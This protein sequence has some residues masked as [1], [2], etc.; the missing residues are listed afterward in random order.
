MR[1]QSDVVYAKPT[2]EPPHGPSATWPPGANGSSVGLPAAYP[3]TTSTATDSSSARSPAASR[4]MPA[5]TSTS[6]WL[7]PG[8]PAA[9]RPARSR[10]AARA[11]APRVTTCGRCSR[12]SGGWSSPADQAVARCLG[13]GAGFFTA[14]NA[15]GA[16]PHRR[17][18]HQ[19]VGLPGVDL[20]HAHADVRHR[21]HPL[22]S[23]RHRRVR[24]SR[25]QHGDGQ[26]ALP[27]VRDP[28]D[29]PLGRD[30]R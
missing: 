26:A 15:V 13:H 4:R 19:P 17:T 14:G 11:T 23:R 22:Q 1:T 20:D 18:P 8:W 2:N 12:T 30:R 27:P 3:P 6:T 16:G 10:C 25:R 29:G 9:P 21:A 7:S 24:R 28:Q 5:P